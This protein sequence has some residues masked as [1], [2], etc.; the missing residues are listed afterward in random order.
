MWTVWYWGIRKFA[1]INSSTLT[2][3]SSGRFPSLRFSTSFRSKKTK[4][5]SIDMRGA[6]VLMLSDG[7]RSSS[8]PFRISTQVDKTYTLPQQGT[9]MQCLTCIIF[10]KVKPFFKYSAKNKPILIT[11][12]I[13]NPEGISQKNIKN[14]WTSA[15]KYSYH[16][17]TLSAYAAYCPVPIWLSAILVLT[18]NIL[19]YLLYADNADDIEA[20]RQV[21]CECY[22]LQP[23]T[24][25]CPAWQPYHSLLATHSANTCIYTG[26][27]N[28]NNLI[29]SSVF[30]QW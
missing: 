17:I 29:E 30:Q 28:K 16:T 5:P 23:S 1:F 21:V 14:T 18:T 4:V 27:T 7:G 25:W 2:D 15:I 13:Q 24:V 6:A 20:H 8:D 26:C 9:I 22:W 10:E 3:K 19:T 12:Y 11:F